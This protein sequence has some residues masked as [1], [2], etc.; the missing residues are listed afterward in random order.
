M[1]K[2]SLVLLV[3][4]VFSVYAEDWDVSDCRKCEG[5]E[6]DYGEEDHLEEGW[7]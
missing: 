2:F 5:I 6:R 7:K 1:R 3:L 4:L